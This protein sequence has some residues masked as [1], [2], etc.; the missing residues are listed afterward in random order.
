[1]EPIVKL[2]KFPESATEL[3]LKFGLLSQKVSYL[4]AIVWVATIN[5]LNKSRLKFP[6]LL[7]A[8]FPLRP[9]ISEHFGLIFSFKTQ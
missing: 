8:F 9:K 4:V 1:M 3:F 6:H 5:K 2:S 7:G